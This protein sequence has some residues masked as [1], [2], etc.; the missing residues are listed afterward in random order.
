MPKTKYNWNS[1]EV[2]KNG[3]WN[4]NHI[5]DT[6][7]YGRWYGKRVFKL[8]Y[9]KYKGKIPDGL[10]LDH[11]CR[12]RLCVNPEHLEP[13]TQAENVRR[14]QQTK[15]NKKQVIMIRKSYKPR[16]VTTR[17]LAKLFNISHSQVWRIINNLRWKGI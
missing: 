7:G 14:G 9:E 10:Q 11:L 5:L 1:Y 12:N 16:I 3:C 15:L 13:V 4:W 17:H 8:F 2:D 6:D